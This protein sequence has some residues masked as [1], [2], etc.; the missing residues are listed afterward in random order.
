MRRLLALLLATT[1]MPALAETIPAESR[2]TAVTVYPDGAKIT[3]EVDFTAASAGAHELLVTDL[4]GGTETRLMQLSGSAG[5]SFGAFSLRSDRLP[6]RPEALTPEQEAAK[7]A[8]ETAKAAERRALAAVEAVQARITAANAS[9]AFLTSF[10][11]TLPDSATPESLKAMAEMV[12]RETLA[13]AE[14]AARAKA[15]LW[16]AQDALE[17][18]QKARAEAQAAYDALP[19][20][21]SAYTALS[22][23]VDTAEAGPGKITIT[24]YVDGA[25][26]RPV[27]DLN[28]TRAGGNHLAIDRAVMVSQDT[29]ED[30]A[31]VALTLSTSRPADQAAPSALWPDLRRIGPEPSSEDY[32]RVTEAM[33]GGGAMMEVEPAMV[34]AP[35]T[36][37]AAIEGDTVVYPYPG[38]VDIASGVEDLRLPL[39]RIETAPVV[40]AKAVPRWDRSAFVMAEFVNPGDEPLLPGE[41]LIFREGVL[42]GSQYLDLIAPGAET[43][44]PFGALETLRIS[45]DMPQRDSGQTGFL[46]TSNEAS[47]TAVLK[48]E[49]LGSES[50]PVRVYDQIPYSEQ[51]DLTITLSADPAPTVQ[52]VDGQRGIQQWDFDLAAGEKREISLSYRMRWPEGMVLQ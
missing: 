13:A 42:V 36:A 5:I 23:A 39:D 27:Y 37:T 21:D 1:A 45:R 31:G 18:A 28:L 48:L 16:A 29:G 14:A 46:S 41:A 11:G 43:D 19:A 7:T 51:S 8:L 12:G 50:W 38:R 6:P 34:P 52:D 44:L 25:G 30:W 20:G 24:H 33:P 4:P 10:S 32:A 9:A 2:I 26:W 15:D 40:Y 47:E 22:V 17:Q 49:N 35:V 3:R